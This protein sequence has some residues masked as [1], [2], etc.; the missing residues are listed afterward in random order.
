MQE[1]KEQKIKNKKSQK[2]VQ[3]IRR[4]ENLETCREEVF[5]H[6][7]EGIISFGDDEASDMRRAKRESMRSFEEKRRRMQYEAATRNDQYE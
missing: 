3:R 5:G 4:N 7:N 1:S 6:R 2:V